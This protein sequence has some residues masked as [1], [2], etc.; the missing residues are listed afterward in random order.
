MSVI[1]RLARAELYRFVHEGQLLFVLAVIVALFQ[2][3]YMGGDYYSL[4][5]FDALVKAT[6]AVRVG[7]V[8]LVVALFGGSHL[9]QDLEC[10]TFSSYVVSGASRLQ[11][12]LAKLIVLYLVELALTLAFP[13]A[14]SVLCCLLNGGW[15]SLGWGGRQ[16]DPSSFLPYALAVVCSVLASAVCVFGSLAL[17]VLGYRVCEIAMGSGNEILGLGWDAFGDALACVMPLAALASLGVFVALLAQEPGRATILMTAVLLALVAIMMTIV[18]GDAACP[19]AAAHP[20]VFLRWLSER[21]LSFAGVAM[22]EG[23]SAL[24]VV[25]LL[26]GSWLV[27][28]ECEL[29]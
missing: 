6:V 14:Y 11:M 21:S 15:G 17:C 16:F 22:G 27:L 2:F 19:L 10:G 28:R 8:V 24:W 18:Q 9:A 23:F 5:G 7:C 13:L 20:T 25:S 3:M 26:G 12:L 1:W 4:K 29:S